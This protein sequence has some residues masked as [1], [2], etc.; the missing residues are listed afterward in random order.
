MST[1]ALGRV[2]PIVFPEN[3]ST[4]TL[5][6]SAGFSVTLLPRSVAEEELREVPT[7][8]AQMRYNLAPRFSLSAALNA[9]YISNQLKLGAAWSASVGQFTLGVLDHFGFWFGFADMTGFDTSAIG[10]MNYPGLELGYRKESLFFTLRLEGIL[11]IGQ[12]TAFGSATVHRAKLNLAGVAANFAI[13][14]PLSS[15]LLF[16]S[17][18]RLNLAQPSYH[19]WL[20]FSGMETWALYPELSLQLVF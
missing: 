9:V 18:L 13:E 17:M 20:A 7:L 11:V 5:I 6:Y 2:E 4:G 19:A 8:A 12:R 16:L 3:L 15:E 14:Q 1:P 10:L